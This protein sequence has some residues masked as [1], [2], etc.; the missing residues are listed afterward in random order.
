MC[1]HKAGKEKSFHCHY[2]RAFQPF[3]YRRELLIWTI[4]KG[5]GRGARE[6]KVRQQKSL[7][8]Q[9]SEFFQKSAQES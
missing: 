2:G 9:I 4:P 6:I 3:Q 8:I 5:R 1:G 7:K